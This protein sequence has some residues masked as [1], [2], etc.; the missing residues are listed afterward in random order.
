M[1][2][3]YHFQYENKLAVWQIFFLI[4]GTGASEREEELVIGLENDKRMKSFSCFFY[5]IN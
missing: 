1:H 5:N 3:A 2:R 4:I